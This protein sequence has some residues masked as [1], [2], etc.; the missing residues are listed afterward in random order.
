MTSPSTQRATSQVCAI[1]LRRQFFG[2]CWQNYFNCTLSVFF[3][4][5]IDD[6]NL[7]VMCNKKILQEIHKKPKKIFSISTKISL[8]CSPP[9]QQFEADFFS[10]TSG[11][12]P[13][14]MLLLLPL[15]YC[16]CS[17]YCQ[18]LLFE[19]TS[20]LPYTRVR[21]YNHYYDVY[22]CTTYTVHTGNSLPKRFYFFIILY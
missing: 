12:F 5:I 16:C 2:G 7:H 14:F 22:V 1:R 13:C 9:T 18:E 10:A 17:F 19:F 15:L 21:Y 4:F 6:I 20:G 3:V 11:L 8:S